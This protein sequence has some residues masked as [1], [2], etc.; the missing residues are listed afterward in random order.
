MQHS[1][2]SK[3][4]NMVG[5]CSVLCVVGMAQ[6]RAAGVYSSSAMS[7]RYNSDKA[8][9]TWVC[10]F[11]KRGPHCSGGLGGEPAGDLFGPYRVPATPPHDEVVS[12]GT[13]S[14]RDLVEEQ[15]RRGGKYPTSIRASGGADLF[16]HKMAKKVVN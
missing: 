5:N 4:V 6:K 11:C 16:I 8:D 15:K 10:V 1:S 14:D 12:P 3:S 2:V 9:L 13:V 7:A